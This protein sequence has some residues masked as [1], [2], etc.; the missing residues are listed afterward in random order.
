LALVSLVAVRER[1]TDD[2]NAAALDATTI[3]YAR[4]SASRLRLPPAKRWMPGKVAD[5]KGSWLI[6]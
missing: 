2:R 6:L 3:P 5:L 1:V 4:W